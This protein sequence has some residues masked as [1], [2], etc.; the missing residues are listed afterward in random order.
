MLWTLPGD[1]SGKD[2][3]IVRVYLLI[4]LFLSCLLSFGGCA[5]LP[6]ME[7]YETPSGDTTPR[8]IGSKGQLSPEIS[9]AIMERLKGQVEPTDIIERHALLIEA[10]SGSPLIAGNRVTLLIDGPA[11][12]DAMLNAI[13]QARDTIDFE[14]FIIEDDEVGRR[15]ADALLRKQAEG[16]QVRLVYDSVGSMKTPAAFFQR[17][18]DGGI[19]VLEFNPINPLE[20]GGKIWRVIKRDHRKILVVDGTVAFTGGVNISSV[21]SSSSSGRL[22]GDQQ[23]GPAQRAWRDTHVQIV[24][25]AVAEFQKLFLDTWSRL[26]GPES[27]R[28][29]FPPLKREGKDLVRVV[30]STPGRENRITYMMYVSAFTY[31]ENSIHLTTPYFAPDN[32]TLDALV[33]A[34][35]RGVDVRIVLPGVSDSVLLYHAGRSYYTHLLESGVKLYERR[36]SMIHA[37]TAVIDNIWST[38]G[39]TNMDLTSFLHNDEVNAIILGSDF[40]AEMES[41]F[42]EDLRQ[43]NRIILEEWKK[44]PLWDRCREW[45][46]KLFGHWL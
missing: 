30:G 29:Y 15:F 42:E 3:G 10:V 16:V 44:R 37:K 38:V 19:Q 5:S 20:T 12:Y 39:S 25:P 4:F 45:F 46:I 31:A 9:K 32:Q 41:L 24:G 23:G 8:I 1:G 18:R 35:E 28:E 22:S 27:G 7:D 21:Y 14:T 2:T 34:A 26:K 43:S 36:N 13:G 17:L 11:T 33:R 6:R 40:A